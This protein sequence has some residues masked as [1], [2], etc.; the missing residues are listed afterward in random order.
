MPLW[1]YANTKNVCIRPSQYQ[2]FSIAKKGGIPGLQSL[3]V[4]L[5]VSLIPKTN[6]H[7]HFNSSYNIIIQ[8]LSARLLY[9]YHN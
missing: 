2:Y 1:Y 8:S 7:G 4:T 3:M 9:S 5:A 6:D